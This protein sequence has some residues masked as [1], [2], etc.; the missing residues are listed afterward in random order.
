MTGSPKNTRAASY[1]FTF[2]YPTTGSTYGSVGWQV[3]NN[4]N[5]LAAMELKNVSRF[6]AT[7]VLTLHRTQN[8]RT[9]TKTICRPYKS[10]NGHISFSPMFVPNCLYCYVESESRVSDCNFGVLSMTANV[11]EYVGIRTN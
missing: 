10:V 2:P 3:L 1:H 7:A 9:S 5:Q 11:E 6:K 8:G 4:Q